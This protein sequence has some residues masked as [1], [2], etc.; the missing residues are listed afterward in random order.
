MMKKLQGVFWV[1]LALLLLAGCTKPDVSQENMVQEK[2]I[3]QLTHEK[4]ELELL[5][6]NEKQKHSVQPA[7]LSESNLEEEAQ[8][9]LATL[10]DTFLHAQFEQNQET[11]KHVTSARLYTQLVDQAGA[12]DSTVSFES[13]VISIELYQVKMRQESEAKIIGKI[14]VQTTVGDF[15]PNRYEQLVECTVIKNSAGIYQVDTEVLTNLAQ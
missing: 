1:S 12:Y 11:L 9:E 15:A 14:E 13:K 6:E 2:R 3:D 8:E 5:L 10:F 4:K 7:E